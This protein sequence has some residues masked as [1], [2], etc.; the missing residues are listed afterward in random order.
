MRH[1][2]ILLEA[3]KHL[4][5]L[6]RKWKASGEDSDFSNYYHGTKRYQGQKSAD[7]LLS[8]HVGP[9]VRAFQQHHTKAVAA[10]RALDTTSSTAHADYFEEHRHHLRQAHKAMKASKQN[11]RKLINLVDENSGHTAM[12]QAAQHLS[13][14]HSSGPDN[15]VHQIADW[16]RAPPR[17]PRHH[18]SDSNRAE[19]PNTHFY[20]SHSDEAMGIRR[21]LIHHNAGY[22]TQH[23]IVSGRRNDRGGEG[24][25]RHLLTVDV[26]RD[27]NSPLGPGIHSP[28]EWR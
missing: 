17:D 5:R 26:H 1:W 23:D 14:E 4:R 10:A 21:S 18:Y 12:V 2:S 22:V 27:E 19:D 20:V 8:S 3:D 16:H 24:P 25:P 9:H 13:R 28:P 15:F 7:D 11:A 6:E